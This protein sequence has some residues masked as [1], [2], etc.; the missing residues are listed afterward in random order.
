MNSDSEAKYGTRSKAH[1]SSPSEVHKLSEDMFS[2]DL[3]ALDSEYN[4]ALP[5]FTLKQRER[6]SGGE[7]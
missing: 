6:K 2:R 5:C 3:D 4:S 7:P 1:L